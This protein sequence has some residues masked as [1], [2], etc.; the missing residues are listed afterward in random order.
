LKL[1]FQIYQYSS[2]ILFMFWQEPG[3]SRFHIFIKEQ[4]PIFQGCCFVHL[5]SDCWYSDYDS[6]NY[7][8]HSNRK[9]QYSRNYSNYCL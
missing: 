7:Y 5:L 8:S 1:T 3:Q 9:Y 4:H 2:I 6:K